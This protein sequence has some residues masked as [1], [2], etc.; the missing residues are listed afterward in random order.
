[1]IFL[2]TQNIIRILLGG[3]M[4]QDR[5]LSGAATVKTLNFTMI[6]G[7]LKLTIGDNQIYSGCCRL[8]ARRPVLILLHEMA[9]GRPLQPVALHCCLGNQAKKPAKRGFLSNLCVT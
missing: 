1:M 5:A 4:R 8:T 3:G 7:V 9:L 2:V 6:E